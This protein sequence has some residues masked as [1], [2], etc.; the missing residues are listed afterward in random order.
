MLVFTFSSKHECA[1]VTPKRAASMAV[2]YCDILRNM[3]CTLHQFFNPVQ[4]FP[5]I[6]SKN[7]LTVATTNTYS[8]PTENDRMDTSLQIGSSKK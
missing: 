1:L 5:H 4:L 2:I 6:A 7:P 8:M 3:M